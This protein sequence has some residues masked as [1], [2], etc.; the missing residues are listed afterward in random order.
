M[1]FNF[2]NLLKEDDNSAVKAAIWYIICQILVRGMAF[3]SSPIFT[4]LMSREDFGVVSN[5]FAW[6]ALLS[7]FI[8]LNL[9]VSINKSKYDFPDTNDSFLASILLF[10]NILTGIVYIFLEFLGENYCIKIFGMNMFVVRL[11][12]LHIIFHTAFEFQQIQHNIYRK[13]KHYV[14]YS[15]ISSVFSL[16]L[17]I[18][19]VVLMANK[20]NGRLLG[21][22]LPVILV[23]SIIIINSTF[24][25]RF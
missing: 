12:F 25:L 14:F 13:Y 17:S 1:K 8:T 18:I 23:N 2:S 11:L 5:F 10:A 22:I 9:R 15:I 19:L 3:L 7:P 6:E 24:P 16:L 20:V 21:N 4:R